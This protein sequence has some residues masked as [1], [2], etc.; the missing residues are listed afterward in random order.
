METRTRRSVIETALS[1]ERIIA[2]AMPVLVMTADPDGTVNFFNRAWFEFTGQAPFERDVLRDW[3]RYIH[4]EDVRRVGATWM[5]AVLDNQ[6]VIDMEY[7]L[8]HGTTGKYRWVK[9]RAT[10]LRDE[11]G[12]LIQWIGTA[13]DVD[14]AR[15]AHHRTLKIAQA[16]QSASLPIVPR[17]INSVRF[18][19]AYRASARQLTACGDWYDA[20]PLSEGRTAICIGDV[21][22]HGLEAAALMTKYRMSVRAIA[23]RAAAMRSGGPDSVLCSVEDAMALESPNATAT[24]F[25]GI[26][27]A[28]RREL[29]WANA[30]HPP[31]LLARQDGACDWLTA[32]EPP[33]GWRFGLQRAARIAPLLDARVLVLYTDGLIE[34]SRNLIDGMDRLREQVLTNVNHANLAAHILE[35]WSPAPVDDDVAILAIAL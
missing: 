6:D 25:F 31:P 5:E 2:D 15:R 28:D 8:L 13:M 20:F 22:G 33:L 7:R 9:A 34:S 26:V 29:E 14:D 32:G 4:P 16:Y 3:Q 35:C 30:G 11:T 19:V 18:S 23:L 1:Y 21:V 12:A 27:S 24:A 17:E 10:A